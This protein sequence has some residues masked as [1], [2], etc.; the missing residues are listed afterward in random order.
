MSFTTPSAHPQESVAGTLFA[1]ND[2]DSHYE[3]LSVTTRMGLQRPM[4]PW[5]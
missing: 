5:P 2:G 1:A 3:R 4:T